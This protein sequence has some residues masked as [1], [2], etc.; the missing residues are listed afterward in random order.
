MAT[1]AKTAIDWVRDEN[2]EQIM[3]GGGHKYK[4]AKLKLGEIDWKGSTQ[5][6]GRPE[7]ALDEE[8]V[9]EIAENMD[10]GFRF[11]MPVIA[12]VRGKKLILS[13][14]HRCN[15]ARVLDPPTIDVYLIQLDDMQE[16]KSLGFEMNR[17]V[18][19]ANPM[20]VALEQACE[21]V[22]SG[23]MTI[24]EACTRFR[25]KNSTL[26]RLV[27]ITRARTELMK[28]NVAANRLGDVQVEMLAKLQGNEHV[29]REAGH[30]FVQYP[31]SF[32]QDY[33]RSFCNKVQ[34][35]RTEGDQIAAISAE[36][37]KQAAAVSKS[38]GRRHGGRN[39]TAKSRL[40]QTFHA[41]QTA[42]GDKTSL[43]E[44]GFDLESEEAALFKQEVN[45]IAKQLRGLFLAK[46]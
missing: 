7:K 46:K 31:N 39:Y 32:P 12:E 19:M 44:F 5:N 13:G 3:R 16:F 17:V 10:R 21:M 29:F 35:K 42:L 37:E 20:Q 6:I 2:A 45:A 8:R 18:G 34:S 24:N 28:M 43:A 38:N 36:R 22:M 40:M 14:N 30:L 27:R 23:G 25:V 41:L 1:T 15:G 33:A 26:S 9:W 4:L 11:P